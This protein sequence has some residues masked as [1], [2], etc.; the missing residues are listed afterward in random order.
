MAPLLI[1]H[2]RLLSLSRPLSRPLSLSQFVFPC[3]AVSCPAEYG[4][5][6]G[7]VAPP[8]GATGPPQRAFR[9]AVELARAKVTPI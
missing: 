2:G 7:W 6:D 3:A 9:R 4:A 5:E 1:T 8:P